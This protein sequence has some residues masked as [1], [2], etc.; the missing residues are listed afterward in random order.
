M[1]LTDTSVCKTERELSAFLFGLMLG[2][3]YKMFLSSIGEA[4]CFFDT[5][6]S[7][8]EA[9]YWVNC[10]HLTL[11]DSDDEDNM[12]PYYAGLGMLET[13]RAQAREVFLRAYE[14]ELKKGGE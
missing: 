9:N 5:E 11:S 6:L 2:Q 7:L 1:L 8:C 13:A 4:G 10:G 3:E 12:L 14:T